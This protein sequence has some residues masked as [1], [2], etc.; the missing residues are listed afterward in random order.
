MAATEVEENSKAETQLAVEVGN[1]TGVAETAAV[2]VAVAEIAVV[3]IAVVALL[4]SVA[5]E[6]VFGVRDIVFAVALMIEAVEVAV[7]LMIEAVEVREV[8]QALS[9]FLLPQKLGK[10]RFEC[11]SRQSHCTVRRN[12]RI[13]WLLVG[14]LLLDEQLNPVSNEHQHHSMR[15]T[16][17]RKDTA[18]VH[19][20][21]YASLRRNIFSSQCYC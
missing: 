4:A 14:T 2:E 5:F 16:R 21:K 11:Q 8:L 15:R 9:L 19:L 20:A 18:K 1:E 13:V 10:L 7:A 6:N 3:E 12:E 17:R